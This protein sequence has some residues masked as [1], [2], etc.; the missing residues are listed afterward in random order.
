MNPPLHPG[1]SRD[2][3]QP[4]AKPVCLVGKLRRASP[5]WFNAFVGLVALIVSASVLQAATPND[6]MLSQQW[7]LQTIAAPSA[8]AITTGS[9]NIVVAVIDTGVDYTHPDLAANMWRNP[10][11][12]GIDTNGN[13]KATNGIDDDGNGYVDDV[14]GANVRDGTGDVMDTGF[15]VPPASP[16][17]HGTL[18]AGVIGAVGNNGIGV[19]GLN[20]SVQMMAVRNHGGDTTDLKGN[21]DYP[22]YSEMLA[23]FRYVLMMKRRGVNIRVIS[24]SMYSFVPGRELQDLLI[25]LEREGV[26]SVFAAGNE[27]LNLDVYSGFPGCFNLPS[28]LVIGNSTQTDVLNAGSSYGAS[29]VDLAAPGTAILTTTKGGGYATV[30]GTSFSC[31]LVAG[32]AALLLSANPALTVDRLK[33]AL[34]GSVDQSAALKGKVITNGRLNISRA[35]QYL[36]NTNPP[37]IITTSL[38]AGQRTPTNFPIQVTFNRP[39]NRS[40]VENAFAIQPPISGTFVWTNGDRSCAFHHD[41][42]FDSTTNYTVRILGTAQDAEGG[43][44]DGDFD[45]SL[46]GSPLD[47]FVWTFRFP[48]PNDDFQDAQP[49]TGGSGQME[50]NNRY[51]TWD[52]GEPQPVERGAQIRGNTVWYRWSPPEPGGWITFDLTTGTTFDTMLE[53]YSGNHIEE[54]N[55]VAIND[56]FGGQSGSRISLAALPG[57]NYSIRV[58]GKN[59][60][61]ITAAGTFHL[62]WY[63]MPPPAF[64]SSPFSR[65]SAY[66]GQIITLSGTNFLGAT[67]VLFNGVS[68]AFTN[69]VTTNADFQINVVVPIGATS[70]PITIETPHGNITS[71]TVFTILPRPALSVQPVAGTNLVELSWPSTSGFT[72]QLCDTFSPT[73]NWTSFSIPTR[74]TNGMRVGTTTLVSSNRFFRLRNG[75]P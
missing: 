52:V 74:L 71:T 48:V 11:E 5:C 1:S 51:A 21:S 16:T 44:L 23:G 40:S 41:A 53:V 54:L 14:H 29:S 8:W 22:S 64:S 69:A 15:F 12:T 19:A 4:R 18:C 43:T 36:T 7:H 2:A 46:E 25:D 6:P 39:M 9:T 13:S 56:N 31:P 35:F 73:G 34:F 58:S 10:G 59:A 24:A 67:D 72:L 38:P 32:A 27:T 17:Y 61:V 45:R 49:L 70:G 26:I 3:E 55:P 50:G 63:P 75:N 28:L 37:A 57:T 47:D 60:F 62:K 68:A 66:S 42:P 20:W 65:N 30:D 33:A